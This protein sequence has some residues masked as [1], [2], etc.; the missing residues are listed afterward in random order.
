MLSKEE[1]EKSKKRLE[2]LLKDDCNCPECMKDKEAYKKLLQYIEQLEQENKKQNKMIDEM[3]DM[4]SSFDLTINRVA[5]GGQA[6]FGSNEEVK[7]YFEKKVEE[8]RC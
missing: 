5:F 1:I 7:Q 8:D 3:V 2:I 6:R 4:I